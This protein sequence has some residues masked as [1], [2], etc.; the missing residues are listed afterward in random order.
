[1]PL[2]VALVCITVQPAC[3]IYL[4][5]ELDF[6]AFVLPIPGAH[7]AVHSLTNVLNSTITRITC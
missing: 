5:A 6:V 4:Y 2:L 3:L 1:M 7:T